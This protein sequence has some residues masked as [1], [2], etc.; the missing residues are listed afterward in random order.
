MFPILSDSKKKILI[1]KS[2]MNNSKAD[3]CNHTKLLLSNWSFPKN[4]CAYLFSVVRFI[5]RGDLQTTCESDRHTGQRVIKRTA[6]SDPIVWEL[7][8][9]RKEE[10]REKKKAMNKRIL[11]ITVSSSETN[12]WYLR[13]FLYCSA[14]VPRTGRTSQVNKR[15]DGRCMGSCGVC[16]RPAELIV[17]D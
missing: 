9:K 16:G 12:E 17:T 15:V 6:R 3:G 11:Q 5:V 1:I 14:A 8:G 7:N 2:D 10:M 4:L 13:F